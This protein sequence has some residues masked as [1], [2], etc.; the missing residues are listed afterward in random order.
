VP[1][2]AVLDM[3]ATCINTSSIPG[4]KTMMQVVDSRP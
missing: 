1:S 4:G 2:T 3:D